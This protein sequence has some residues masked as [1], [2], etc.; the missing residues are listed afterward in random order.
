[1]KKNQAFATTP[2]LPALLS[3]LA[4]LGVIQR[5]FP[6]L[7]FLITVPVLGQWQKTSFNFRPLDI[8]PIDSNIVWVSCWPSTA[9]PQI[10]ARSTDYGQTWTSGSIPGVDTTNEGFS[11]S[12]P[13]ALSAWFAIL[14]HSS[15]TNKWLITQTVDGG[16]HWQ[17]HTPPQIGPFEYVRLMHFWTPASGLLLTYV[18]SGNSYDIYRYKTTDGGI[19]WV[20][21][22]I[23]IL[24]DN[25]I[26]NIELN[27]SDNLWISTQNGTIFRS[28]NGGDTWL[29]SFLTPDSYYSGLPVHFRDATH[30]IAGFWSEK[31]YV[32]SDAG[33]TWQHIPGDPNYG[34]NAYGSNNYIWSIAPIPG[35]NQKWFCAFN[36]GTAITSNNGATW[37]EEANYPDQIFTNVKFITPERGWGVTYE[38]RNL[39]KWKASSP[40][41]DVA[42]CISFIGPL[43]G[44]LSTGCDELWA[45]LKV[46]AD[47]SGDTAIHLGARHR[48]FNNYY[49]KLTNKTYKNIRTGPINS[50]FHFVPDSGQ[51]TLGMIYF[52]I[53]VL[54]YDTLDPIEIQIFP[55]QCPSDTFLSWHLHPGYMARWFH[56]ECF[57]IDTSNCAIQLHTNVCGF[58]TNTY[59]IEYRIN[60]GAPHPGNYYAKNPSTFDWVEF[61]I[62]KD[63]LPDCSRTLGAYYNCGV[64]AVND[65]SSVKALHVSPNPANTTAVIYAQEP[66]LSLRVFQA[67]S[68]RVFF[69]GKT[70]SMNSGS[71]YAL[72]VSTWPPGIYF[73]ESCN[74]TGGTSMCRFVVLRP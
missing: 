7:L 35:N 2:G 62:Y 37:L 3:L 40:D 43:D 57:A 34:S 19:S 32:T 55:T 30:G 38:P 36:P 11:M 9:F 71:N 72:D 42:H 22:Q 45:H 28:N 6:F 44:K 58:D 15:P 64:S 47:I 69:T 23:L 73:A 67:G 17:S 68:G 25:N 18:M 65:V 8:Q 20:R 33:V 31:M 52:D 26:E 61:Y 51:T 12:A 46:H 24:N 29:Q 54:Y 56:P 21:T 66:D 49:A 74:A 10:F 13:S 53:P 60:G 27:G 59:K 14:L 39:Y 1:M 50:N 70:N 48:N 41:P 5:L 63:N 4:N 16:L